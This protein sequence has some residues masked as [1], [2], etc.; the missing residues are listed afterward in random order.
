MNFVVRNYALLVSRTKKQIC[1]SDFMGVIGNTC[2][3]IMSREE[4]K[5]VFG[6]YQILHNDA[7]QPQKVTIGFKF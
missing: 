7:V 4:R 5:Q 2:I 6:V 3:I 1:K